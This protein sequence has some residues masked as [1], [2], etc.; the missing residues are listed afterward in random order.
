MQNRL[1]AQ[2]RSRQ[3]QKGRSS[4]SF[5]WLVACAGALLAA[6][7]CESDMRRIVFDPARLMVRK[8]IGDCNDAGFTTAGFPQGL[9]FGGA[10]CGEVE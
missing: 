6:A 8:G 5:S 9:H 2:P 3:L 4:Q 7:W 10:G 1:P